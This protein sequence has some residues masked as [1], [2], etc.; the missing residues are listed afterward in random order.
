MIWR[1]NFLLLEYL[2]VILLTLLVLYPQRDK[3]ECIFLEDS[4]VGI[5]IHLQLVDVIPFKWFDPYLLLN[6][7]YAFCVDL[8]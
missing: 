8:S 6:N 7:I 4:I 1:W 2:I 5:E 3:S